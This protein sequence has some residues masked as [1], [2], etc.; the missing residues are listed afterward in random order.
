L[1]SLETPFALL[2]TLAFLPG[3]G[4]RRLEGHLG[5]LGESASYFGLS[6]VDAA[7]GALRDLATGLRAPTRV[8]LLVDSLGR[9]RL[10]SGPLGPPPGSVRVGRAANPV[11]LGNPWLRHKTTRRDV[12]DEATRGRPDCDDV[13]LF[14]ARGEV[15][16]STIANVAVEGPNGPLVTPPLECGLLP[17]VERAALLAEGRL[18]EGV[19]RLIDLTPGQ[20]LWLLNSVRGLYE[21]TFVG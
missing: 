15:T 16:E 12:Y 14:N 1:A 6:T 8:R 21:A 20:R 19:I 3:E 9:V 10:E 17:G 11:D 4:Y 5:R 2:E 18:R 13:L 7:E